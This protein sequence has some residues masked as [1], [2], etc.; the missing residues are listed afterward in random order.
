MKSCVVMKLRIPRKGKI[1]FKVI[2]PEA[3]MTVKL[4]YLKGLVCILIET[5]VRLAKV[6]E[7]SRREL[8]T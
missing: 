1:H 2:V 6:T 5:Q 7:Q 3:G 4:L 8:T